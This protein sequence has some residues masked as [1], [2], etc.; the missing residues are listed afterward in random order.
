MVVRTEAAL[1]FLGIILINPCQ[2][3]S[4]A[5]SSAALSPL[6]VGAHFCKISLKFKFLEAERRVWTSIL[7]YALFFPRTGLLWA[8]NWT[9]VCHS[10]SCGFWS[11][12]YC[13]MCLSSHS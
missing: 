9:L 2:F 5:I 11:R 8:R 7:K 12:A 4:A 10:S 6:D 1:V 3:S 13:V